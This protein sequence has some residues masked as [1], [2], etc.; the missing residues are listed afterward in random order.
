MNDQDQ[1]RAEIAEYEIELQAAK[2]R[3]LYLFDKID[4]TKAELHKRIIMDETLYEENKDC[5]HECDLV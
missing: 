2:K 5:L 1:L 3:V 4:E